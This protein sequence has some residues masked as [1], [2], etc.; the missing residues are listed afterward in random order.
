MNPG[1]GRREER[2]DEA[3]ATA[4]IAAVATRLTA[5]EDGVERIERALFIGNGRPPFTVVVGGLDERLARMEKRCGMHE[6]ALVSGGKSKLSLTAII[7]A[8]VSA[9]S[10]VICAY[11]ATNATK[12][13]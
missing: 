13:G 10:S 1:G 5:V 12:S 3:D 2:A 4:A 7:V 8:V 9:V 11:L 6:K